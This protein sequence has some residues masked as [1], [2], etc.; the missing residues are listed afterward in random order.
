MIAEISRGV[1]VE[2]EI[3]LKPIEA[4]GTFETI[5]QL[6]EERTDGLAEVVA[7]AGALA[8]PER[9]DRR[10]TLSRRHEHTIRLDAFHPPGVGP[11]QK[12]IADPALVDELLVQLADPRPVTGVGGVLAGIGDGAAVDEGHLLAARQ[13]E[14]AVVNAVPARTR[15]QS[16]QGLPPTPAL[17]HKGGGRA[18]VGGAILRIRE[19]ITAGDHLQRGLEGVRRQ[20][21]VGIGPAD[22]RIQLRHIPIVHRGAGDELLG[23]HVETVDRH[24]DFLDAAGRHLASQHGLFEQIGLRFRNEPALALLADQMPRPTDAL[25]G[26]GDISR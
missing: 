24:A 14:Q 13:G 10:R 23:Q 17:P 22:H 15:L 18:G 21:A 6:A 12:R 4:I 2:E 11:Q 5:L 19:A 1:R 16:G 25:K 8:L 9:H 7:A 3:A 26:A 20:V